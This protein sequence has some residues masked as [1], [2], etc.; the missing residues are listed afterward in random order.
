MTLEEALD[1]VVATT[2][3]ERY[4]YLCLE[5]PDEKVRKAYSEWVIK[6]ARGENVLYVPDAYPS[7]REQA[8]SLFLSLKTWVKAGMP[9]ADRNERARRRSICETCPRFDHVQNRCRVCGCST[10][11]KPWL[12]SAK[13]PENRWESS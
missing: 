9:V 10:A 8:S 1:I 2:K 3:V 13:C 12:L 11:L 6:E 7:L 5:Y 4:R